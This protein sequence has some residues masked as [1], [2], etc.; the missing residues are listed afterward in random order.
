MSGLIFGIWTML[1]KLSL[2]FAVVLSFSILGIFGFDQDN[3]N[4]NSKFA[5][6][7]TYGLLPVLIKLIAI[8]YIKKFKE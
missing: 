6:L 1:T 2:A 5:V 8:F 3:I 4:E 7:F